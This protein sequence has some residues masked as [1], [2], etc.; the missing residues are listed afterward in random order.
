MKRILFVDDEVSVLDGLRNLLRKQRHRWDMVFVT[1]GADA[2]RELEHARFDVIVSDLRMPH[3]DGS[4]LLERVKRSYPAVARIVLSG[5]AERETMVRAL[6]VAHQLLTKPCD[7]EALRVVIERTCNLQA[8]LQDEAVRRVVGRIDKLPS[9]PSTYLEL[10]RAIGRPAVAVA[11]L[12]P[13]VERDPAMAIRVLQLVNSGYFGLAQPVGSIRQAVTYL[14]VEMLKGLALS[15]SVFGTVDRGAGLPLE[16]LQREALL[17][18]RLVRRF[19]ARDH[20]RAEE[21]FTAAIVRDIGKLVLSLELPAVYLASIT[22][23]PGGRN[24]VDRERDTLGVTHAEV[25]AW[26]LGMWGLPFPIVEAVAHHHAPG[27]VTEGSRE[28]LGAVHV[29]DVWITG[30][31]P[32]DLPFL[33]AAGLA[34]ELPKWQTIA[35]E[36][37]AEPAG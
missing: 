18:A 11:D 3:M 21:G 30:D 19:L 35:D 32:L 8:L 4:T 31:G 9:V 17:T 5:H 12:A 26:L 23:A 7:A 14:G 2:L 36:V 16:E 27:R 34:R 22:P 24:R 29:A 6:P 13:I 28:V 1:S 20:A 15:A 25:G 10:T 37:L 33:E